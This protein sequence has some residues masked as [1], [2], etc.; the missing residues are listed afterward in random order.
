MKNL[1]A[2]LTVLKD[3]YYLE[4]QKRLR[5]QEQAHKA[6]VKAVTMQSRKANRSR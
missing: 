2:K 3:A 1:K 6:L 4:Q 5:D